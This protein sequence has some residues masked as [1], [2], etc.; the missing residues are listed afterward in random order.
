MN[1]AADAAQALVMAE[2]SDPE[3]VLVDIVLPDQNG[4]NLARELRRRVPRSLI[5][6]LTAFPN[7]PT[8]DQLDCGIACMFLKPVDYREIARLIEG[9]NPP[10]A[11]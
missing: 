5:M 11:A 9:W 10:P 6:G 7:P 3:V 2:G 8:Q 4:F 1:V